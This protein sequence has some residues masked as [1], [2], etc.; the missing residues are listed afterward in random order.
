MKL[1]KLQKQKARKAEAQIGERVVAVGEEVNIG[2]SCVQ[3][4]EW[5]DYAIRMKE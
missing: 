3:M 4:K 2:S 5:M 1:T